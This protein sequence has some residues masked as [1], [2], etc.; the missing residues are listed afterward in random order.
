MYNTHKDTSLRMPQGDHLSD[1]FGLFGP[2]TYELT[3]KEQIFQGKLTVRL[4]LAPPN[5]C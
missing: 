3:K 2:G 5:T 1:N 4:T